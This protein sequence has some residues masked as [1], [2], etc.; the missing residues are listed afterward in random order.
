MCRILVLLAVLFGLLALVACA[1]PAGPPGIPGENGP[2]GPAG[3]PGPEGPAGERGP[4]GPAGVAG[5]DAAAATFV[6]RDACKECH[7]ELYATFQETGHA[8]A[9]V[10]IAD[11]EAPPFPFTE[12]DDP[13]E[14]FTW[15][16]ILYVIGGYNWKARFVD[17]Q[18]YLITGAADAATQYN[19]ENK[20]LRTDDGW[21]PYHAGEENLAFDCAA[22]HTTG[23]IPEGNQEGLPG[24][25]GI[26][27]EDGV[28]CESCHGPGSNHVN[29][30]Y[31]VDMKVE[32]DAALCGDC[33]GR[34][35]MRQTIVATDGFISHHDSTEVP[36]E[37]KKHLLACADCH[38][39][40]TTTVH[41]KASD[42]PAP[43][44][45]CHFAAVENQKITDRKHAQCVDCHMPR[46][47][48]QAV[49]D[50]ERTSGDMRVHLMAINPQAT[51]QFDAKGEFAGPYLALDFA[52]NGCHYAD[53]RGPELTDE[54]L[55]RVA[56]GYH[57]RDL[58]GSENEKKE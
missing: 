12:V 48:Q 31:L 6:G 56:T 39:P 17:K 41:A 58:V 46:I 11:G 30:P 1:A 5:L 2:P 55:T 38:N 15:D 20:R 4:A 27:H 7:E 43:C 19:L 53:G 3:P 28:G 16:E 42:G 18:G 8:S 37:S 57:D 29:D 44:E 49:A 24:L 33:H 21:V 45:G 35:D 52:C 23:Y 13:P 40:H 54:E 10:R 22:C 47:I 36:F 51:A 26:W 50:P 34:G 14:G 9:L 25:T 32:R